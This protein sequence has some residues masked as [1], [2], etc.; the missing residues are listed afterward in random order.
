[1]GQFLSLSCVKTKYTLAN[2][3]EDIPNNSEDISTESEDIYKLKNNY[4]LYWRLCNN[5]LEIFNINKLSLSELKT[6]K[7]SDKELYKFKRPCNKLDSISNIVYKYNNDIY[8]TSEIDK[9]HIFNLIKRKNIKNVLLPKLIY[10]KFNMFIEIYDYYKEGDLF[11][12]VSSNN[13]SFNSKLNLLKKIVIIIK[14]IHSINITHRDI[15]LENFVIDN[16]NGDIVPILIDLDYANLSNQNT[17]FRGGTYMYVSPERLNIELINGNMKACDIWALGVVFYTI[18]FNEAI[19]LSPDYTNDEHY[20][21]YYDYNVNNNNSYWNDFIDETN[22][23]DS[24][25]KDKFK[26]IFNYCFNLDYNNRNNI[27]YIYDILFN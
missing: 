23:I 1:M 17:G 13:L 2:T 8:K 22:E 21:N 27:L 6:L 4:I 18:I 11:N 19:W 10:K 7:L 26:K 16:V 3:T 12:Y 25:Y 15:K 24:N 14:D 9:T 20:R 5:E